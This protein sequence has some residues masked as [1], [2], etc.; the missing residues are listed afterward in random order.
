[1]VVVMVRDVT[2]TMTCAG[3]GSMWM[4]VW[5]KSCVTCTLLHTRDKTCEA[6]RGMKVH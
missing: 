6:E 5:Y 3:K 4:P 2:M 1:M